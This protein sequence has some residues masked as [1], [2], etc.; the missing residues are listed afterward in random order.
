MVARY[1]GCLLACVVVLARLNV[2][3]TRLLLHADKVASGTGGGGQRHDDEM[4]KTD[5]QT[6]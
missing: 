3:T 2:V 6:V 1:A 4:S 5:Q